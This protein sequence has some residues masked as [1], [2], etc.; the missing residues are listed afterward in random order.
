MKP[1]EGFF[2][3]TLDDIKRLD[4]TGMYEWIRDFPGQI[5][6]AVRIGKQAPLKLNVR[7]IRNIVVTG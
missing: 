3:M 6:H 2:L 5:E 4:P 7:G 1:S